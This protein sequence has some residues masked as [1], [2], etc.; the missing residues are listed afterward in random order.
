MRLKKLRVM[1][2]VLAACFSWCSRSR[3]LMLSLKSWN[4]HSW[5]T[6]FVL[7]MRREKAIVKI[8][9]RRR[10][11]NVERVFRAAAGTERGELYLYFLFSPSLSLSLSLSLFLSLSLSL[12]LLFY[13]SFFSLSLPSQLTLPPVPVVVETVK[14]QTLFPVEHSQEH[15]LAVFLCP[16]P[17]FDVVLPLFQT[18]GL[19]SQH[20]TLKHNLGAYCELEWSNEL[21]LYVLAY[22][23][24]QSLPSLLQPCL[25]AP[26]RTNV[27]SNSRLSRVAFTTCNVLECCS[28]VF[29][30]TSFSSSSCRARAA[31]PDQESR[32]LLRASRRKRETSMRTVLRN[33]V[34]E[35]AVARSLMN[36]FA[37][38]RFSV[39]RW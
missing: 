17:H 6:I 33:F 21:D 9:R 34:R 35:T 24:L 19:S 1:V 7:R 30:M 4:A 27:R 22:F 20:R 31:S 10:R 15:R 16:V 39:A 28:R 14:G 12:S 13:L 37:V 38:F 36:A 32:A 29:A 3:S 2:R 11:R 5:P 25:P 18:V 26:L 23:L 8:L